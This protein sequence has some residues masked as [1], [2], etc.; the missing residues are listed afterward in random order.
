MKGRYPAINSLSL[1]ARQ[2]YPRAN[3][4]EHRA[5]DPEA[6]DAMTLRH[7]PVP[8]YDW[9]EFC[10]CL[11]GLY[12]ESAYAPSVIVVGDAIMYVVDHRL[13]EGQLDV[14]M[15]VKSFYE[16]F[17]HN[18]RRDGLFDLF[19][20]VL[21]TGIHNLM[22]RFSITAG[23]LEH[24]ALTTDCLLWL[25]RRGELALASKAA[26]GCL[27]ADISSVYTIEQAVWTCEIAASVR[28]QGPAIIRESCGDLGEWLRRVE[29]DQEIITH[30]FIFLLE[31]L[32]PSVSVRQY[33]EDLERRLAV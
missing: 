1:K 23:E 24:A 32:R 17:E 21:A 31:T 26:L 22:S 6:A 19:D 20:D 29:H 2:L 11:S 13:R 9:R 30:V 14:W 28:S 33:L 3:V 18:L 7:K 8:Q 12:G 25:S 4:L 10:D 16:S 15:R 27:V 5:A